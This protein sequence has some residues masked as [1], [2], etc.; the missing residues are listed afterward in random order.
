M[1]LLHHQSL[2]KIAYLNLARK[3]FCYCDT[4][5]MK[6][7]HYSSIRCFATSGIDVKAAGVKDFSLFCHKYMDPLMFVSINSQTLLQ[8]V[9]IRDLS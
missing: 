4:A 9:L 2:C 6:S 7:L 3:R 1:L 5:Y 8:S